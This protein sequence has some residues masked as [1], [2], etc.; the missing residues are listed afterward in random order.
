[1]KEEEKTIKS[2]RRLLKTAL[3][4]SGAIIAGKSLPE[5]WSRPVVDAVTLPAHAQT[6]PTATFSVTQVA[7]LDNSDSMFARLIEA[8]VPDA[9]AGDVMPAVVTVDYCVT[10]TGPDTANFTAVHNLDGFPIASYST[11]NV[12]VGEEKTMTGVPVCNADAGNWL[13]SIGLIKDA[14]ASYPQA[15]VLLTSIT[16]P[17]ATGTFT[18]V[19]QGLQQGFNA[20][21]GPCA[22][23]D[24]SKPV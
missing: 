24:C 17:V 1:M 8:V 9:H 5:N 21:P 22:S 7:Q 12:K 13:D 14:A 11:T 18:I 23:P 6:S 20:S 3:A 2:R 10:P 19:G 15:A 16:L 4:G